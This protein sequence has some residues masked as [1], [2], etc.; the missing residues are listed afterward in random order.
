MQTTSTQTIDNALF[1]HFNTVVQRHFARMVEAQ[2]SQILT[3][4][5]DGLFDLYLSGFDARNRQEHNCACC[6]HFIER[7]GGLVRVEDDGEITSVLWP[8][9]HDGEYGPS[10]RL[11]ATQVK[12]ARITGVFMTNATDLGLATKGGWSHFSVPVP[13]AMRRSMNN[14][15]LRAAVSLKLQDLGTLQ[16]GL[17]DFNADTINA[18]LGLLRSESLY[19]SE[20]VLGAGEWLHQVRT[21]HDSTHGRQRDALMWR[22]VASAPVGFCTPRSS[23]IGTLLED[24]ASGMAFDDVKARFAAKMHPL[25]Y[26]RPQVAATAGNI[27]QGEKVIAELGLEPSL[28]RRFAKLDEIQTIWQ[29]AD[30]P[31]ASGKGVFGHLIPK[32]KTQPAA[33]TSD[34]GVITWAKFQR[35]VLPTAEQIEFLLSDN[36]N[37]CAL[38]TAVNADAPPILQWDSNSVRNPVSW[39]VYHNGSPSSQWGMPSEGYRKVTA[40][41]LQPSMW[42]GGHEYQGK[43]VIFIIDGAVDSSE[44]GLSLFPEI[45]RSELYPIRATIEAYSKAG[46]L[47]G[48]ESASACGIRISGNSAGN[49]VRVTSS[50]GVMEYTIDRWD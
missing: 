34:A 26:Q 21:Q 23:M 12:Q 19:R 7:F 35:T 36:M 27:A 5:T 9:D 46:A 17:A 49:R 38:L 43:S 24:I 44:P 11:M 32:G 50:T 45:L 2:A 29:P 48:R 28:A 37:W 25:Q 20:K 18:A 8:S 15:R 14:A 41:T 13:T 16:R 40:V 3:V 42:N 10:A 4:A 6:R 39:Y 33:M 1:D 47:Q 31:A 30:K 22:A